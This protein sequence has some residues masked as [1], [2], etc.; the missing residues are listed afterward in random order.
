MLE[1]FIMESNTI[2]EKICSEENLLLAFQNARKGKTLKLYVIVFEKNLKNNLKQIRRELLDYTYRPKPLAT[3]ILRDPKTRKISKSDFR[4]RIVHHALIQVIEPI[5]D[6]TF[7]YDSYANRIGKGTLKA[8]GRFDFFKRKVSKNN[9]RTCYILKAD[10]R[11]YFETISHDILISLIKKKIRD[12]STINLINTILKNYK[13]HN[14]DRGMPLGNLTSQFFANVYLNEF[15]HFVKHKL[16]AKHYIRYVDDFV[17]LNESK[18]LLENYKLNIEN[19]LRKN[20]SLN[21]HPDKSKVIKL[22]NG[23]NFLGFRIFYYHK[24]L[25]KRNV[26]KFDR[27]LNKL[28][29]LYNKQNISRSKIIE[30]FL[31]WI[32]YVTNADT[33]KYKRKIIKRFNELFSTTKGV[34]TTKIEE[35]IKKQIKISFA[36]LTTQKTLKLFKKALTIKQIAEQRQIKESTVYG[37]LA[38]LIKYKQI[39]VFKILPREKIFKIRAK[40]HSKEDTLKEIRERLKEDL[41]TYNEIS[42]VLSAVRYSSLF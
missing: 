30:I 21:L 40:I 34:K 23:A 14:Y 35:K 10:I 39:S 22:Q 13:N 1:K 6:K 36:E 42:L 9:T 3:F 27:R 33:Y 2:F 28:K 7:I 25:L 19:F 8:V 37:H 41:F 31:G 38:K 26:N 18:K 4:D 32:S 16:K 11:H 5:F 20:L 12:K 17:I 24:L 15:D 29:I